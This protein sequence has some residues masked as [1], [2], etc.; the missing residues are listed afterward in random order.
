MVAGRVKAI[1]EWGE[2]Q[3][4]RFLQRKGFQIIERNFYCPVGEIDIVAKSGDDFYFVEVKTRFAGAL[5]FDTAI[6][7][8]KKRKLKKTM[9]L[10]CSRKNIR[11][12]GM[13]LASLMVII[14]RDER[15]VSFRLAVMY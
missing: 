10:Y 1:G 13:V 6:T 7:E 5:A 4:C 15:K 12:C 2:K 3:A 9:V 8:E 11:D 14:S